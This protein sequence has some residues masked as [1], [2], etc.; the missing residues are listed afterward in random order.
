MKMDCLVLRDGTKP[1]TSTR[2]IEY[3]VNFKVSVSPIN[4]ISIPCTGIGHHGIVPSLM[5]VYVIAQY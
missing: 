5:V 1:I 4:P 3:R 2:S